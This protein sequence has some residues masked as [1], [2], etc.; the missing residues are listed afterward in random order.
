MFKNG[1]GFS[2]NQR[3]QL[4]V[5][6]CLIPHMNYIKSFLKPV[7]YGT[8]ADIGLLILRAGIGLMMT[9]HGWPKLM[10]YQ[11][12]AEGFFDFMGLGGPVSMA[13]TIF[14]ELFCSIF[15]VLGIGTRAILIPLI[16]LTG[17]ITFVVHGPDPY[18]DK[19]HALLFM[20]GYLCILFTGPGKFSLDYAILSR[21]K[22]NG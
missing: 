21:T 2:N 12:K 14:A 3:K 19:E 5:F 4:A 10:K 6:L 8:T 22:Q 17:V 15:L 20:A 13:L 11:D 7:S 1:A 9:T 18:G 16:I